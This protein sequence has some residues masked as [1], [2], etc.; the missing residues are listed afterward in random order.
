M[1]HN[2]PPIDNLLPQF[3]L[4]NHKIAQISRGNATMGS[5]DDTIEQACKKLSQIV[6]LG[7]FRKISSN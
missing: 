6:K 5:I 4:I 2:D 1:Q 7:K 3:R